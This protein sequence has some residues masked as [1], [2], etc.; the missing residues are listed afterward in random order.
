MD[1][2]SY[3]GKEHTFGK[4]TDF[5]AREFASVFYLTGK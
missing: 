1:L 4:V 3:T 5:S 2:Y